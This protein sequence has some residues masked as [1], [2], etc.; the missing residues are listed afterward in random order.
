[1]GGY[2]R[3]FFSFQ[4]QQTL[5]CFSVLY[6]TP[7]STQQSP[8][9]QIQTPSHHWLVSLSLSKMCYYLHNRCPLC[10]WQEP[11][12]QPEPERKGIYRCNTPNT[13][14]HK[15]RVMVIGEIK[16]QLC[17]RCCGRNLDSQPHNSPGALARSSMGPSPS[18]SQAASG[19]EQKQLPF[20]VTPRSITEMQGPCLDVSSTDEQLTS[21]MDHARIGQVPQQQRSQ[22]TLQSP[23]ASQCAFLLRVQPPGRS[24]SLCHSLRPTRCCTTS[25]NNRIS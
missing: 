25:Y 6:L 14:D 9:L 16:R 18:G 2:P 23:N 3:C 17:R 4:V 15:F 22:Q 7:L 10:T 19:N 13:A 24:S 8:G 20:P 21:A 1:M 12:P 5:A 11:L